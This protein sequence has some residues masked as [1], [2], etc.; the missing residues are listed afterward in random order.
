VYQPAYRFGWESYG[1]Y[2]GRRFEEVETDL[3]RDWDR[4]DSRG[5]RTWERSKSAVRDAWHKIERALPGDFDKDG[6]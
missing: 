1:R 4:Y 5:N 6:R 3:Q 2:D